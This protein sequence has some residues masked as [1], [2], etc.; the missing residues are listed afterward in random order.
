M[1]VLTLELALAQL[2][3]RRGAW[4]LLASGVTLAAVLPVL[5]S[6]TTSLATTDAVRDAVSALAPGDRSILVTYNRSIHETGPTTAI[7]EAVEAQLSRLT[8]TT[9]R[10]ELVYRQLT[11]DQQSFY[12]AGADQL[13]SAVQLPPAASP[14]SARPRTARSSPSAATTRRRWPPPPVPSVWT[15]SAP[16]HVPT[17]SS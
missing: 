8:A 10:R 11:A 6:G 14:A 13:A 12:L 3:H 2:R 15:S 9:P 5:A 7:D 4:L 16:R 1:A 17:R